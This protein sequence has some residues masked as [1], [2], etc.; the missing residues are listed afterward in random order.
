M[1]R[2]LNEIQE[3]PEICEAVKPKTKK[4]KKLDGRPNEWSIDEDECLIR[5]VAK[6]KIPSWRVISK[7]VN[8]TFVSKHRSG[9]Q[10]K[11]RWISLMPG[12]NSKFPWSFNE[13]LLL[14]YFTSEESLDWYSIS[15]SLQHKADIQA[16]FYKVMLDIANRAKEKNYADLDKISRL[17]ILQVFA[18]IKLLIKAITHHNCIYA[19]VLE[20][21]QITQITEKDCY[22]LLNS[23]GK[24]INTKGEWNEDRLN[25]YLEN[26]MENIRNKIINL[27]QPF[28]N[29]QDNK[30]QNI[31]PQQN[32]SGI[33]QVLRP[34][35]M[36]PVPYMGQ[37]IFFLTACYPH[38]F[39]PQ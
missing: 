36:G 3:I 17:Y 4:N 16:H 35:W 31:F 25:Q 34:Y 15:T 22:E 20:I 1:K 2:E 28:A 19:E 8:K 5:E 26:V 37:E 9:V 38:Q 21:A 13:E 24:V 33:P 30:M 18:C 6:M 27:S 12:D 10:C 23:V 11:Q 39:H 14:L 7:N 29:N 32:Q